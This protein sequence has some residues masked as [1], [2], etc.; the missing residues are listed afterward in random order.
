M[1]AAGNAEHLHDNSNNNNSG[2]NNSINDSSDNSSNSNKTN[3]RSKDSDTYG[4][5]GRQTDGQGM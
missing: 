2:G 1:G 3:S 5:T 4:Q